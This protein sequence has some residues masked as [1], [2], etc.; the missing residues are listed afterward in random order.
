MFRY[1]IRAIP[2]AVAFAAGQTL[3]V[4]ISESEDYAGT[5]GFTST[6]LGMLSI[7][8]NTIS[9]SLAGSCI[10]HFGG[11]DCNGGWP[12][13]G[14]T[15]DS[16]VFEVPS[17]M[18]LISM[19]ASSSNSSAP[20]GYYT[21]FSLNGD[22]GVDSW[23]YLSSF[24]GTGNVL[25]QSHGPG[26]Y[27]ASFYGATANEPGDYSSDWILTME[28][29]SVPLPAATWLFGSGILALA[30]LSRTRRSKRKDF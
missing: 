15:Q 14:D 8:I 23:Q 26:V 4:T 19:V 10:N 17:G 9:G 2:L 29:T 16:F 28:L 1:V 27:G 5:S 12:G 7:G 24:G 30:S 3:A 21:N 6:P 25:T 13:Y 11:I 22:Y 18:Q 20:D